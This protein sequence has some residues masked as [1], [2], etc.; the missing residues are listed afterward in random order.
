MEIIIA[1]IGKQKQSPELE[2][3]TKYVKQTRWKVTVREFEDKKS[4][5]VKE[6]MQKEGELLLSAVPEGGVSP[7]IM[8]VK[9]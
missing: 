6:R 4:S 3:L 9:A 2:L 5:G 8:V 7:R 1:A